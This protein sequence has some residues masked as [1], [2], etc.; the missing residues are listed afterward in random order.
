MILCSSDLLWGIID[1]SYH[2]QFSEA[3]DFAVNSVYHIFTIVVS[4]L[5]FL[6]AESE[7]ESRTISTKIGWAISMIP[8]LIDISLILSSYEFD[9]VFRISQAGEYERGK[10][11]EIHI[12]I[13][14]FYIIFTS[15]KAFVRSFRKDNYM[16]K[17]KLRSIASFCV[18]PLIAGVMQ[19][20]FVGS[21]MISAGV[22]FASLQVYVS[23]REQLISIDPLTKL[24]NRTEMVRF[25]DNKMK[26]RSPGKD[27]YLFIM[28]LDY[29]KKI[30]D[31]YGHTEGDIAIT[32]VA[33]ALRNIVRKTNFFVCRYGGDEFVL[34]GEVKPDFDPSELREKINEVLKEEKEKH[35]KEYTLHMSV[36]Y[37]KYTPEIH[38]VAE[39]V[40][41]ADKYLYKQKSERLLKR[42]QKDQSENS[43]DDIELKVEK[44]ADKKAAKKSEKKASKKEEKV[45]KDI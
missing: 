11:Y 21:S 14:F 19:V 32:I 7:Q 40:S 36:G 45:Q 39:F 35:N 37:F 18:F 5:W 4:Y 42:V 20:L 30:N 23:S 28:D 26:N 24:N 1:F 6:Y 16:R 12:L 15:I 31:K 10:L 33:D 3:I 2:W 9:S 34:I 41:A 22:T 13:C 44:R 27:L 38:S 8:L 17:D 29:F 43:L 25:L